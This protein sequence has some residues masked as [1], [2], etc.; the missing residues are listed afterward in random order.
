MSKPL[1]SSQEKNP[2][3]ELK[4]QGTEEELPE[5]EVPPP[6][7]TVMMLLDAYPEK[8]IEIRE[9]I[10]NEEEEKRA[11][12]QAK[13]SEDPKK[14]QSKLAESQVHNKSTQEN[15]S[16]MEDSKKKRKDSADIKHLENQSLHL[17][18]TQN[19]NVLNID[20]SRAYPEIE[21][22]IS[23]SD[24]GVHVSFWV[25]FESIKYEHPSNLNFT[26]KTMLRS[27]ALEHI[28]QSRHWCSA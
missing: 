17:C 22:M 23:H 5:T 7:R 16:Q 21:E 8:M 12:E 4:K 9:Q 28:R 27:L 3:K 26:Q 11:A 13:E 2:P 15:K 24:H 20:A 6:P 18:Y 10:V 25:F 14:N 19:K 1:G